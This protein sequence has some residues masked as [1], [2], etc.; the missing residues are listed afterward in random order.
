MSKTAA[1]VRISVGHGVGG[2]ILGAIVMCELEET[3][4]VRE[5]AVCGK[6]R[7]PVEAKEVERELVFGEVELINMA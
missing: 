1:R 4:A 5:F 3:I 2:V 6:G 7:W